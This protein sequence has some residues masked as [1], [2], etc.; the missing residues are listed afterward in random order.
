MKN[1]PGNPRLQRVYVEVYRQQDKYNKLIPKLIKQGRKGYYVLFK[2]KVISYH[3]SVSKAYSEGVRLFG[4]DGG[5]VIDKVEV[6]VAIMM[7]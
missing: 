7:Y 6:H 4:L 5:F 3:R 1:L 2:D